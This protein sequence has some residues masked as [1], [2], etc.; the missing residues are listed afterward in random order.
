MLTRKDAAH[1]ISSIEQEVTLNVEFI[2]REDS[3]SLYGFTQK[4]ARELF[5]VLIQLNGIGP[6]LGLVILSDLSAEQLSRAVLTNDLVALTAIS[7]I[8]KKTA[9]RMIIDLKDKVKEFSTGDIEIVEQ[10]T[11]SFISPHMEEEVT[12]ALLALGYRS[13]E[14]KKMLLGVKADVKE[15]ITIEELITLTLKN[16]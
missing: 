4:T 12:G 1:L 5:K 8:G 10:T 6:K 15:N 7:G 11:G 9:E 13:N 2:V 3:Q 16:S 14:A